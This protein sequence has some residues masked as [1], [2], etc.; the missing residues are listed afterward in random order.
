IPTPWPIGL[1]QGA[2]L[3]FNED[4][5]L[6]WQGV[7]WSE[8]TKSHVG[9]LDNVFVLLTFNRHE[10]EE[11]YDVRNIQYVQ[12]IISRLW[13]EVPP[14]VN[15]E[16]NISF[17]NVPPPSSSTAATIIQMATPLIRTQ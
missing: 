17:G 9:D 5:P 8:D 14:M 11:V 16:S 2:T 15:T 13:P 12:E 3:S 7:D 10:H 6:E 1:P 4:I